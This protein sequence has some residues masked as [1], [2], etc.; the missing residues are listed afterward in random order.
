MTPQQQAVVSKC[1]NEITQK[2]TEN[3]DKVLDPITIMLIASVI[4]IALQTLI[5][6]IQKK[7]KKDATDIKIGAA[8]PSL[9]TK[10][11]IHRAIMKAEKKLEIKL[12]YYDISINDASN[13]ILLLTANLDKETIDFINDK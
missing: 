12:S 4:N 10:Y 13:Q 1:A 8:R 6:I 3:K 2:L 7:C 5:P 11:R 9:L